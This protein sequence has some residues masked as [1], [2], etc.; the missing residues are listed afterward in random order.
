MVHGF[1]I[2]MSH[3]FFMPFFGEGAREKPIKDVSEDDFVVWI[4]GIVVSKSSG[5][6]VIDD[7]T[8]SIDVF[9]SETNKPD[10]EEK[11]Y[12]RVIGRV[13]PT[14]DGIELHADIIKKLEVKNSK[15]YQKARKIWIEFNREFDKIM[16]KK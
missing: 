6:L 11:D 13:F 14:P 15:L 5:K 2:L 4:E 16:G 12:A 3:L 9:F 8:S 10:V 7:G 1:K